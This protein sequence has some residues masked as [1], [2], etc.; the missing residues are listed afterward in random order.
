M[1]FTARFAILALLTFL[2]G[3]NAERVVSC[4]ERLHKGDVEYF[5]VSSVVRPVDANGFT[6]TVCTYVAFTSSSRKVTD[7]PGSYV[8]NQKGDEVTCEYSVRDFWTLSSSLFLFDTLTVI[9]IA[10]C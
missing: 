8:D 7:G 9:R 10:A 1:M 4:A 2:A 6:V 5:L 3:A